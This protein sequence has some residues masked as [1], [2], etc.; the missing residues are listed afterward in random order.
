MGLLEDAVAYHG[1]AK[2][3]LAR[4]HAARGLEKAQS[5]GLEQTATMLALI[6]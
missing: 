1:V 3:P 4:V 5:D 2:D 6:L